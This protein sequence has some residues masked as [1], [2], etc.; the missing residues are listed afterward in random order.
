MYQQEHMSNFIGRAEEIKMF[1][2]WLADPN[3]PRILYIHD[4]AEEAEKKGGVGKTWLLRKCAELVRQMRQDVVIVMIDFFNVGDRDRVFLAEKI[5][6]GLQK[7][8]PAWA[9][10]S[11]NEAI[12]QYR[13]ETR[14]NPSE[15][16]NVETRIR[17]VVSAALVDDLR[18]LDIHLAQ[19]QKT[20]LVFI[21]TFEAI[22]QNPDVAVL[23]RSQT[24]PDNYQFEH[25]RT[26]IAG[27][28]RLDWTHPNWSGREQEL[29]VMPLSPFNQ[30]E[31][32]EY[33]RIES[34]DLSPQS[35]RARALYERTEGRPIIIGL[36]IDVLNHRIL[37]VDDLITVSKTEFESYLVP[38]VN[39]LENPLNWVILFMAHVYHHFNTSILEWILDGVAQS[40]PV[41]LIS[42]ERLSR[43]LP[44]L[45]FVRR[46]GSGDDFVLH[47]EMR[48]LVTRYCWEILDTGQRFRKD[49]SRSV[50][51]YYEQ[52]MSHTSSEQR[53]QGYIIEMLYHRLFMNLNDGLA[54]FQQQFQ[55]SISLFKTAFARL[56]LQEVQKFIDLL[57]LAQRNDAQFAE[58]SLLHTEENPAAALNVLLQLKQEVDSQWYEEHRS[59]VL[60]EEGRCYLRQSKLLEA[61]NSF[62]Q[63]LKIEQERGNEQ[64]SARLLT[65]LGLISR[66]R[67]QFSPALSYYEQSIALYKKLGQQNDYATVL[68]NISTLCA[69]YRQRRLKIFSSFLRRKRGQ[70]PNDC[71]H[72]SSHE[73]HLF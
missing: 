39:K 54:Y 6:T 4:K 72:E 18:R 61:A 24:F 47:D 70:R 1:A 57:P 64:Q 67:G 19:E 42:S 44:E 56:L 71:S 43:T 7:L 40:E 29:Q 28:N 30:Q 12:E 25:M 60:Q 10:A 31:M 17:E 33:F 36:A 23:L 51:S 26:V 13:V 53:R 32:L 2:S 16:G 15:S 34:I 66:R 38:Q 49:I 41:E 65:N 63:S 45:S 9:P 37:T 5:I 52:A 55:G 3:A 21:D 46:S 35:E 69:S 48:R 14:R 59:D 73:H 68:T 58:A 22:E 8:Y 11:F 62:T 27:R 50:V 20:L